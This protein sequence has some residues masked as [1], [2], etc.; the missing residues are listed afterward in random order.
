MSSS[1]ISSKFTSSMINVSKTGKAGNCT[2]SCLGETNVPKCSTDMPSHE[3]LYFAPMLLQTE[4]S[5]SNNCKKKK[6]KIDIKHVHYSFFFLFFSFF[7]SQKVVPPAPLDPKGPWYPKLRIPRAK[8][9]VFHTQ[10][11]YNYMYVCMSLSIC[12]YICVVSIYLCNMLAC[13]C[14]Y[15]ILPY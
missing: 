7:S 10:A 15:I 1:K 11:W 2:C 6:K 4:I 12:A 3:T 9:D 8:S 5:L 14:A 13:I